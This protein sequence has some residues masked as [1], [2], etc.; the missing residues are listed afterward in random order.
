MTLLS[1]EEKGLLLEHHLRH[2][3]FPL[4]RGGIPIGAEDNAGDSE[5]EG[6]VEH[7][8][9]TLRSDRGRVIVHGGCGREEGMQRRRVGG[10]LT[11]VR[12]ST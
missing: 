1:A 7:G 2:R 4:P 11:T 6:T 8:D 3:H 5:L 12:Q 10:G 9:A